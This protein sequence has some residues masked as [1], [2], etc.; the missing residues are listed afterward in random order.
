MRPISGFERPP[1]Q[2]LFAALAVVLIAVAGGAAWHARRTAAVATELRAADEGARL[3]RQRLEAQ[4]ARERSSREALTLELARQ[5]AGGAE[6]PGVMPTLTL[7]PTGTRGPTPPVP[8]ASA[9]HATQVIELRLVLPAR[10]EKQFARFDVSWRDWS[11]GDLLWSRGGMT[12]AVID[13]QAMVTTFLIGDVLRAGSYELLLSGVT[14]DG[15]KE[16]VASYE[17]AVK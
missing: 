11:G 5:R 17:L 2:W 15:R 1:F 4:L 14:L 8:T 13:R 9:Q 3:E 12:A 16:E 6:P 10:A 7:T